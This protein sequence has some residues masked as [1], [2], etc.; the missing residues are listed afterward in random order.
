MALGL[1]KD[2]S[3]LLPENLA[4]ASMLRTQ[5][6]PATAAVVFDP[7]TSGGLLA[8]VPAARA[9]AW[10][11]VLMQSGYPHAAAIGCVGQVGTCACDVLIVPSGRLG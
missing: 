10:V 3:T 8:G 4:L 1:A 5:L 2:A 11:A 6:D 7:Q 9:A